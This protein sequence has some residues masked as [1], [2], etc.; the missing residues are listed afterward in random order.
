MP[1]FNH[2]TERNGSTSV[3]RESPEDSV[4]A[5]QELIAEIQ[6]ADPSRQE[7]IYAALEAMCLGE[8]SQD[9][10]DQIEKQARSQVLTIQ[11]ALEELVERCTPETKEVSEPAEEAPPTE[12]APPQEDPNAPLTAADVDVV[13]QDPRGLILYR[14]KDGKRW[15]ATQVD[16][17]TGQPQ[18]FEIPPHEVADL[19]LQLANSPYWVLGMKPE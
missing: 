5:I 13:F 8:N 14:T 19:K 10:M 6:G 15:L 17:R 4:E 12:E 7:E 2:K 11:W 9:A 18:S 3:I 16:P 1:P